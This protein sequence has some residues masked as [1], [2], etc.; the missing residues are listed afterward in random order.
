EQAGID[1]IA[2][3]IQTQAQAAEKAKD[4]GRALQLYESYVAQCAG[5]SKMAEV[6]AHYEKLKADPA[7]VSSAKSQSAD[8]ECKGW[9]SAADNYIAN[10]MGEKAK[11]FLQKILDKYG[12]TPWAAEAR[13]RMAAIRN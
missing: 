10:N 1:G 5:A 11:P 6:K 4:F 13:K 12:A 8:R 9:L 3:V 2:E 7:I